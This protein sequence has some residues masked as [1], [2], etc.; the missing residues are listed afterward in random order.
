[1][2]FL[3]F[4]C[5]KPKNPTQPTRKLG[6]VHPWLICFGSCTSNIQNTQHQNNKAPRAKILIQNLQEPVASTPNDKVLKSHSWVAMS[7]FQSKLYVTLEPR[8]EVLWNIILESSRHVGSGH[9]PVVHPSM[10]LDNLIESMDVWWPILLFLGLFPTVGTAR[11]YIPSLLI[12]ELI[13]L[14]EMGDRLHYFMKVAKRLA[15][16]YFVTFFSL[17]CI[18]WPVVKK[19]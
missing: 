10:M 6:F 12:L 17:E 13:M 19:S 4:F 8:Q 3:L 11:P 7:G 1:M 15:I 16:S 18:K 2:G 9:I 5:I 14:T